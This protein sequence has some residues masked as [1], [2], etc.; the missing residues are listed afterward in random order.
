LGCGFAALEDGEGVGGFPYRD[1]EID[2]LLCESRHLVVEAEAVFAFVVRR[3]DEIAL[4]LLRPVQYRLLI[5]AYDGEV[6]IKGAS[7]LDLSHLKSVKSQLLG[8]GAVGTA[9]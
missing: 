3:E 9:K 8:R 1:L 5:G 2:H 4:A 7:G 6:D